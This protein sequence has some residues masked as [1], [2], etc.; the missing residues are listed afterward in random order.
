MTLLAALAGAFTVIGAALIIT[1]LRPTIETPRPAAP[2]RASRLAGISPRTR[3]RLLISTGAGLV[4]A[5]VT[6]WTLML[7]IVPAALTG[8]PVLLSVPSATAKIR[9]LDAMAD[10]TRSLSGTLVA[11]AGLDEAIKRSVRTAPEAIRPEVE[12]LVRRMTAYI[13]TQDALRTFA[14][15]LDDPTGDLLAANLIQATTLQGVPLTDVLDEIAESI[16]HD[17]NARRRVEADRS[18]PRTVARIVTLI[19]I[20]VQA[21]IFTTPYAAPFRTPLGQVLLTV[22]L[23]FFAGTLVWLRRMSAV[24]DL[25]RFLD[26]TRTP[27]GTHR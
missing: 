20:A 1:G 3:A 12:R 4:V 9:R 6:G 18:K 27:A 22:E 5:L 11:G 25:P 26:A 8:L 2:P 17:V 13:P 23:L 10:W 7:L 16:A 21:A 14:D 19:T 24:K 15:D